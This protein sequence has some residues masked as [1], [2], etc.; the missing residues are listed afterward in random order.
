MVQIT[1]DEFGRV[2]Q[3]SSSATEIVRR[4][5]F[6]N[7]NGVVIQV[8]FSTYSKSCLRLYLQV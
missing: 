2:K 6:S 4:F 5:T 7:R 1:E 3:P 8:S